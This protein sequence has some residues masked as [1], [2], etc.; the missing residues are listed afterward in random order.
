MEIKWPKP[1]SL[2]VADMLYPDRG[3]I[4]WHGFI[5]SDHNEVMAFE[6]AVLEGALGRADETNPEQWDEL[7]AQSLRRDKPIVVSLRTDDGIVRYSGVVEQ[8]ISRGFILSGP[9]GRRSIDLLEVA[10]ISPA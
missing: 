1:R 10:Q 3:M 8:I 6:Q 9:S 2:S 7:V 5:L 4:K